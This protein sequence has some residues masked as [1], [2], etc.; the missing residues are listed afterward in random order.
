MMK[1]IRLVKLTLGGL[2]C[3]FSVSS[4]A[5]T[6][7][8]TTVGGTKIYNFPFVKRYDNPDDNKAGTYFKQ[9]YQWNL[10]AN[11]AANCDCTTPAMTYYRTVVPGNLTA[12]RDFDGLHFYSINQYLEVA[13]ELW[14]G[15]NKKEYFATPFLNQ[16]NELISACS[17]VTNWIS[18]AN[19]Y[20]SLYFTR[21]FVGE[22]VI[23]NTKI[24]D[25]YGSKVSGS[26]GGMPMSSIY[27]SGSVTVLQS[28]NINAGQVINVDFDNIMSNDIKNPGEIATGFTPK[29]VNMTLAC[30]N[31]SNGV[32]V[33]LSFSGTPSGGDPTALKTD[34]NDIGVRVRDA[35]GN[36]V[37]PINGNLPVT[38]DYTSQTGTSSMTLAPMNVTGN[39]PA[40]GRFNAL[41]TINA[42]IN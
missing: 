36:I 28:C 15:G 8:C 2:L 12:T 18:G 20:V 9:T 42:E 1:L 11:Y 13:T 39:P 30:N 26:Y 14:V 34:N 6:G 35:N 27:M 7:W 3:L 31:I 29:V 4:F 40:L 10:A 38:F 21:P 23:P 33:S 22:V 41:A 5:A 25:L 19:G 32:V 16:P 24:L 17:G 37:P